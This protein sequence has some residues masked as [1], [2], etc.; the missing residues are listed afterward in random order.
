MRGNHL[1][2]YAGQHHCYG[3]Q[4]VCCWKRRDNGVWTL[5]DQEAHEILQQSE[6]LERRMWSPLRHMS[7]E[8][9]FGSLQP[10]FIRRIERRECDLVSPRLEAFREVGPDLL[11]A[12]RIGMGH[13]EY[14]TPSHG[15]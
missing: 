12:T 15:F 13:H 11:R 4:Y 9:S 2:G 10:R 8:Q 14:E 1:G 7:P 3:R 6:Q 5:S